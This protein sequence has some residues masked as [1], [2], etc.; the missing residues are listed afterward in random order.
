[1]CVIQVRGHTRELLTA[2]QQYAIN[3]Q[4]LYHGYDPAD[5]MVILESDDPHSPTLDTDFIIASIRKHADKT[6]LIILPGIQYYTGQLFDIKAITQYAHSHNISVGWDL[7]H[8]AGNAELRLHDWNVDFA[9]WCNYKYLNSGPG[10]IAS[11]FVHERHGK[12]DL[13]AVN[14]GSGGY[15]RRLAGWWGGDKNIRFQMADS[16]LYCIL[17]ASL[18]V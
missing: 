6:A 4:V 8:A 15:H 10:A 17:L 7:A 11:L 16:K 12:V 9:V 14:S 2:A 3:S 1:M 5:A 13:A 18:P